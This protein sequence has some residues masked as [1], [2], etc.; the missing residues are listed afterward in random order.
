[1]TL[2]SI[3][4]PVSLMVTCTCTAPEAL[5]AFAIGGYGGCTFLIAIP[6]NT[7]PE[8]LSFSEVSALVTADDGSD[9]DGGGGVKMK[10][11]VPGCFTGFPSMNVGLKTHFRAASSAAA[12]STG[13]PLMAFASITRP[14]SSMI[15][16][17]RTSPEA[18]ICFA[19]DG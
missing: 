7:P 11:R 2:D 3:T 15:T 10:V 13:W 17:T 9:A 19:I 18:F 4:S 8:T 12:R 6:C 14:F 5:A 1:M 16:D